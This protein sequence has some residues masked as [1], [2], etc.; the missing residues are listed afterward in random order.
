MLGRRVTDPDGVEGRPGDIP[1]LGL[2]DVE[3][4][5]TRDKTL[6]EVSGMLIADGEPFRGY[7][8]HI[9]R[10]GGRDCDRPL[11]RFA[12]G[13]LDGAISVDGRVRGTYVHGLLAGDGARASL[14]AWFGATAGEV[15]YEADIDRVLDA[16]AG[17]L[18]ENIDI[19]HL[20]RFAR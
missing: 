12:D 3:T 15:S 7:E 14:L 18:A 17:H 20:L 8:M 16:L 4:V 9:G 1:G 13:R 10:T 5:L 11:L 19:D 2:L 6:T